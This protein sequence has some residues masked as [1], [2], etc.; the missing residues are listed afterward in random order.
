MKTFF[1]NPALRSKSPSD[2][3]ETTLSPERSSSDQSKESLQDQDI[4]YKLALDDFQNSRDLKELGFN[5]SGKDESLTEFDFI[6]QE[7][8]NEIIT[9]QRQLPDDEEEYN[10]FL[11]KLK[12]SVLKNR[13]DVSLYYESELSKDDKIFDILFFNSEF[14]EKKLMMFLKNRIF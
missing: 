9:G 12:T 2:S 7:Y 10:I 13:I 4:E 11:K 6:S 1:L 14:N 5:Y 3:S 8:L